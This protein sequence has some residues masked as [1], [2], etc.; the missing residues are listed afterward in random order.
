MGGLRNE[1]RVENKIKKDVSGTGGKARFDPSR[2]QILL[3]VYF[4]FFYSKFR[5]LRCSKNR[6]LR[7]GQI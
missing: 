4:N 2:V 5:G 6:C 7:L 3:E 1:C